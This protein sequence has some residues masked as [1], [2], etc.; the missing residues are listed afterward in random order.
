M[1]PSAQKTPSLC[2]QIVAAAESNPE[3]NYKLLYPDD[4]P[5]F[6]KIE[7]VPRCFDLVDFA[8]SWALQ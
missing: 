6:Q 1:V 3:G 4:A 8:C 2:A 5:L 7:T